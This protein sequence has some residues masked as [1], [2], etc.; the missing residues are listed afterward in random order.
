VLY[1]GTPQNA[2]KAFDPK[3]GWD[4][5]THERICPFF[6]CPRP[7]CGKDMVLL[8]SEGQSPPR[9]VCKGC[10]HGVDTSL[11]AFTRDAIEAD[12]PDVLVTSVEM[13]NR[14]L[15]NP[16]L[17][18]AFGV[19]PRARQAPD[20][21]LLDEVHLFTGTYGA[22]VG[23]LLRR[24][25]SASGRRSSFVGLSATISGGQSFFASLTGLA[26]AVVQEIKPRD[27]DIEAE[28]AE[29]MLALR[30]DPVSQS[31]LLSTRPPR[32]TAAYTPSSAG[33]VSLSRISWMRRIGCT[34]ICSTPKDA[35]STGVRICRDIRKAGS[36]GCAS[37]M[38][39]RDPAFWRAR[40][41]AFRR[42]SGMT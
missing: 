13:L 8:A 2:K 18:H 17:Q 41:G 39:H 38:S 24:W 28:G 9:L 14:H 10:N 12:P 7:E 35:M 20:L 36:R 3:D 16:K 23:Y 27:E 22:Q 19:G 32:S 26:E 33:A 6:T 37:R 30:G 5:D 34:R 40:T 1:G 11:L 21:M 4:G 25:W 42:T 29:Y 31:A 15:S